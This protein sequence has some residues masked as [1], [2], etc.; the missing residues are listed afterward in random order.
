MI[1]NMSLYQIGTKP[2]HRAQKHLFVIKSV[3]VLA[4][5]NNTA[6]A[7][8]LY[9]LSKYFVRESLTDR[10]NELYKNNLRGKLNKLDTRISVKTPVG[11]TEQRKTG[12]GWG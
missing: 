7:L 8:Q 10:L 4:E 11:H 5:L 9:D 2:G 12:E 3:I 6:I 1:V